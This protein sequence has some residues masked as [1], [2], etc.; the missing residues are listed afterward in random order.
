MLAVNTRPYTTINTG[1][2]YSIAMCVHTMR[3]LC[4]TGTQ[5]KAGWVVQAALHMA[6]WRCS[7]RQARA[8]LCGTS[9]V[10]PPPSLRQARPVGVIFKR[11]RLCNASTHTVSAYARA[12]TSCVQRVQPPGQLRT[13]PPLWPSAMLPN[14]TAAPPSTAIAHACIKHN[15]ALYCRNYNFTAICEQLRVLDG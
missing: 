3:T 14:C 7:R 12:P 4:T 8:P 1:L 15:Q 6:S 13:V 5:E 9:T 2:A 10:L 11:P